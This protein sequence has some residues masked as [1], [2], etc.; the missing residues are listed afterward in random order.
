MNKKADSSA[1]NGTTDTA[2][3]NES[4]AG[5]I[6][7]NREVQTGS[8]SSANKSLMVMLVAVLGLVGIFVAA[9]IILKM[10]L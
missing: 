5:Q 10:Y 1:G 9:A 3:D 4:Q 7:K 6:Q 8:K 2:P